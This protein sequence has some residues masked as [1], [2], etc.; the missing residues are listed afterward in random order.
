MATRTQSIFVSCKKKKKNQSQ[1]LPDNDNEYKGTQHLSR[2]LYHTVPYHLL[3]S[4][5]ETR[6]AVR[7][8]RP[9][10]Q[11]GSVVPLICQPSEICQRPTAQGGRPLWR[12][13][14]HHCCSAR[15]QK[16]TQG[17]L[18]NMWRGFS[19]DNSLQQHRTKKQEIN[20]KI[21]PSTVVCWPRKWKQRH[22]G[23]KILI[24]K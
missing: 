1:N 20:K 9:A 22:K 18:L 21:Q 17:A 10:A 16:D 5:T 23:I 24:N 19:T 12:E 13:Q 4:V 2:K 11:I 14:R 7:R 8:R 3:S 15:L 6:N